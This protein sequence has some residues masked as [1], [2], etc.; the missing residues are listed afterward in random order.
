M[1]D[2]L[3]YDAACDAAETFLQASDV[4]QAIE[5]AHQACAR[6]P[7]LPRAYLI[8]SDCLARR[9][10]WLSSLETAEI[11][12]LLCEDELQPDEHIRFLLAQIRQQE[13]VGGVAR[14]L[15][16][17]S[18]FAFYS[19]ACKRFLRLKLMDAAGR[20]VSLAQGE[21]SDALLQSAA[22]NIDAALCNWDRFAAHVQSYVDFGQ[23]RADALPVSPLMGLCLTDDRQLHLQIA[24]RFI[25]DS[26]GHRAVLARKLRPLGKLNR[27]PRVGYLSADFHAHAT[28][29]LMVG[30]LEQHN[31]DAWDVVGISYGRS[32]GSAMRARMEAAFGHFVDLQGKPVQANLH[33]IKSLGLDILVDVKGYTSEF[34]AA[35]SLARPS[36]V[37]VNYLAYPGSMGS[38][39]YDYIIGDRTVTPFSHQDAYSECIVQLPDSYQCND[40]ARAVPSQQMTR[41]DVG[42]SDAHVVL[43]A[44]NNVKKITPEQ[45]GT[46]MQI[47]GQVPQAVIWFVCEETTARRNLRSSAQKLGIDP[48]RLVF[49]D[50]APLEQHMAR[51]HLADLFLDTF[52]YNAHTTASD[53][54]WMGLPVVTLQGES[55]A[56]RV[57]ASLLTALGLIEL[58]SHTQSEYIQVAVQ[59]ARSPDRLQ[60]YRAHLNQHR[61]ATPLFDSNRYARNL[62]QAFGP[63]VERSR[64]GKAPHSFEVRDASQGG[65]VRLAGSPTFKFASTAG[66]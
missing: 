23:G 47:L 55:F 2:E 64:K 60:H 18:A 26:A 30:M 63:M 42:L 9:K 27:R 3:S 51:H 10:D 40:F 65:G 43:A 37:V 14:P 52:P 41:S 38:S 45:F 57:A 8:I 24:Q 39:A 58:I 46:W 28:S 44:F 5:L 35:Y 29:R 15:P 53:A 21:H 62:E 36:P 56:S 6:H 66:R 19:K 31:R 32:D 4:Q 48:D 33:T 7:E 59:L 11:A 49:S 13:P 50:G 20:A 17:L 54:L 22:I 16:E 61:S 34:E 1:S 12:W 25:E